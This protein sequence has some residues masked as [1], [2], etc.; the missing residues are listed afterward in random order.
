M[1]SYFY[2]LVFDIHNC[3]ESPEIGGSHLEIAQPRHRQEFQARYTSYEAYNGSITN[4]FRDIVSIEKHPTLG[5]ICWRSKDGVPL[6][7]GQRLNLK[8]LV[9]SILII[10]MIEV[11]LEKPNTIWDF[12]DMLYPLDETA[13]ADHG[14]VYD[15]VGHVLLSPSLNH[16]TA[17]YASPDRTTIY[18]Y[19]GM[20]IQKEGVK[21][22]PVVEQNVTFQ[23]HVSGDN[24]SLPP[25]YFVYQAFYSHQGALKA[26]QQFYELRTK[27]LQEHFNVH[28]S[29]PNLD[30]LPSM[31]LQSDKLI[32]LNPTLCR[33]WTIEKDR[34][35]YVS[36]PPAQYSPP[37]IN[38]TVPHSE[39]SHSDMPSPLSSLPDSEFTINCRCGLGGD[40]NILYL[41][42]DGKAIQCDECGD[43]SHIACQYNGCAH[44][45]KK[46]EH[47]TCD[48][49]NLLKP[50]GLLKKPK[51]SQT[52]SRK[53]ATF[54]F[55]FLLPFTH[56]TIYCR[57]MET[58]TLWNKPLAQ[59]L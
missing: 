10:L 3:T 9:I 54:Y 36:H 33:A 48:F 17:R 59:C 8:D 18:T 58:R 30:E 16:F 57:E 21:G 24:I 13:A 11:N 31:T 29:Q 32:Q 14:I 4:F 46:N 53:Y 50:Q 34:F 41:Q 27:A 1:L 12:P 15:L 49:C 6:C 26:Q 47:F 20:F 19:D 55:Y 2:T 5:A 25:G 43:W 45:L 35:E 38:N 52:S 28:L 56:Q 7:P 44:N 23:S 42:Q 40:G 39:K 51:G 37:E 22:I